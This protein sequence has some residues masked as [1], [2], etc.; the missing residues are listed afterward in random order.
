MAH[1]IC[2][3]MWLKIILTEKDLSE[4]EPLMIYFNSNATL[5]IVHNLFQDGWAKH[6]EID[7]YFI[8][9]T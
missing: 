3:V 4:A 1:G 6:I 2:E 7:R 8:K 5:D 9:K